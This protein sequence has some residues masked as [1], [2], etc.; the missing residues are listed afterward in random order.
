MQEKEKYVLMREYFAADQTSSGLSET[1][2]SKEG[3]LDKEDFANVQLQ[4]YPPGGFFA[5]YFEI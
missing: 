2:V 5:F 1:H 3:L 4:K